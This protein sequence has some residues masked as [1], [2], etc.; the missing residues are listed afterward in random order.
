[1]MIKLTVAFILTA[2]TTIPTYAKEFAVAKNKIGGATYLTDDVCRFNK[3]F[4]EAYTT[5]AKGN[6]T[7]ACY[8][9]G[10]TMIYFE[11]DDKVVRALPK[12]D[13]QVIQSM[14]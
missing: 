13:F 3:H 8:W 7:Y 5:D 2:A 4:P 1:M 11:P 10:S 12:K 14:L 6:K 9:F